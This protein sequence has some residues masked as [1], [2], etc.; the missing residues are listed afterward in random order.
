MRNR[1]FPF[2]ELGFRCNPFRALTDGEWA[3]IAILP[4]AVAAVVSAGF[5]HLQILGAR[6]HGKSTTLLA[7][8]ARF[9]CE[10]ERVGY[11]YLAEGQSHFVGDANALDLF[12]LDEAQR[13]RPREQ[14]RLISAAARGVRLVLGSHADLAPLFARHTLPLTTIHLAPADSAHLCTML[15]QRLAYFALN[16]VPPVTFTPDAV[17]Y[18][19]DTFDGDLRAVEQFLYEVFQQMRQAESLTAARLRDAAALIARDAARG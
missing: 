10:G 5:V 15:E 2:H 12:L 16:D 8:A 7:L 9:K 1:Y 6:G 4:D 3:D 14:R 11:E 19:C 17:A 13:L 18:L